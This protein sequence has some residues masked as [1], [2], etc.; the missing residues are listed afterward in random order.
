MRGP[1]QRVFLEP[2]LIPPLAKRLEV[3]EM[4]L[5]LIAVGRIETD[6]AGV[7]H[8]VADEPEVIIVLGVIDL[9]PIRKGGQHKG[10][11][12]HGIINI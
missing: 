7:R 2:S 1:Q 5:A 11:H 8:A 12:L 3:A 10:K 9:D 4:D 6:I